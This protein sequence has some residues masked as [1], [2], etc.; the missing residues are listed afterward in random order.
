MSLKKECPFCGQSISPT[1]YA[2]LRDRI[3]KFEDPA[4]VREL[5]SLRQEIIQ[6]AQARFESEAAPLRRKL[7]GYVKKEQE[8]NERSTELALKEK[9]IDAEVAKRLRSK[10]KELIEAG[11][12]Q[13]RESLKAVQKQKDAQIREL[14]DQVERLTAEFETRIESEL[15]GRERD[16]RGNLE[17]QIEA[18]Y[19]GLQKKLNDYQAKELEFEKAEQ[20]LAL[21]E[22]GIDLEVQKRL[23]G[24]RDALFKQAA[25]QVRET[26][27]MEAKEKDQNIQHLREQVAQ[28]QERLQSGSP[29]VR[30]Y[31]QQEDLAAYLSE[32]WPDDDITEIRR[33]VHGADIIQQVRLRT[34]GIVGSILWESKRTKE[35]SEKWIEKLREDQREQSAD[36]SVLVSLV[37]PSGVNHF[38]VRGDIVVS[39]PLVVD[40]LSSIIRQHLIGMARMRMTAEQRQDKTNELY[41]YMTG[42]EFQQRITGIVEAAVNLQGLDNRE[43]RSHQRLWAE[44]GKLHARVLKQTA[45][46]YGEVAGIVGTLPPVAQLEL[47]ASKAELEEAG[48]ETLFGS[49]GSETVNEEQAEDSDIPPDQEDIPF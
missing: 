16:L 15:K 27:E 24:E 37:L 12:R 40:A 33:G 26:Y 8:L 28:L 9:A 41:S 38:S 34:G 42:R 45:L 35:F 22:H 39:H 36:I 20:A 14:N 43:V 30:G 46:L 4:I 11:Q 49:E 13:A 6:G 1:Q 3:R 32:L 17:K 2:A 5:E 19:G 10:E 48:E 18:K 44:R 25:H 47:P 7:E 21:R 31:L 29:Q 23:S